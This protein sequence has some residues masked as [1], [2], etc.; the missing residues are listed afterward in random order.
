VNNVQDLFDEVAEMVKLAKSGEHRRHMV[1][2]Q[3]WEQAMYRYSY[4]L[5]RLAGHLAINPEWANE[6]EEQLKKVDGCAAHKIPVVERFL[7]EK[8][9]F[10]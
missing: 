1:W 3:V 7:F 8:V 6:L 10:G 9:G 5:L 2:A 4:A